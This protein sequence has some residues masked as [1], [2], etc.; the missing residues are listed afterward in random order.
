[1]PVE[2]LLCT[3]CG[4]TLQ[5]RILE[6]TVKCEYCATVH[7]IVR[8]SKGLAGLDGSPAT[9]ATP[10]APAAPVLNAQDQE[11]LQRLER[12]AA[13]AVRGLEAVAETAFAA[14]RAGCLGALV[15]IFVRGL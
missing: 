7:R 1:M 9:A 4:A 2:A 6:A 15:A 12:D 11:T 8:D 10:A 14:R 3:N 13:L 5:P